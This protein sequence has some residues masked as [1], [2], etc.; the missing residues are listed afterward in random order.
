MKEKELTWSPKPSSALSNSETYSKRWL[1]WAIFFF[2]LLSL[3]SLWNGFEGKK[4]KKRKEKKQAIENLLTG[5]AVTEMHFSIQGTHPC[6]TSK[7]GLRSL[8]ILTGSGL[9]RVCDVVWN[10]KAHCLC[11]ALKQQHQPMEHSWGSPCFAQAK[12]LYGLKPTCAGTAG[13]WNISSTGDLWSYIIIQSS[14]LLMCHLLNYL[15][16]SSCSFQA[17]YGNTSLSIHSSFC[18]NNWKENTKQQ[19]VRQ[20]HILYISR[21][22]SSAVSS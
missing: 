12:R 18:G 19:K 15:P 11:R 14:G 22:F 21:T 8:S 16:S 3:S 1:R 10:S 4:R 20:L 17:A 13:N 9:H 6:R 2:L 5:S 7:T